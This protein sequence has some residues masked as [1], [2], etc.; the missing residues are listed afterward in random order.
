MMEVRIQGHAL[1]VC[2]CVHVVCS[3]CVPIWL[4]VRPLE[5]VSVHAPSSSRPPLCS[6]ACSSTA[7]QSSPLVHGAQQ[8]GHGLC[9]AT[10]GNCLTSLPSHLI[11]LLVHCTVD[12][13]CI[14]E[15]V[16]H[17][18]GAWDV[19]VALTMV[20]SIS[21]LGKLKLHSCFEVINF[22]HQ[23]QNEDT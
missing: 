3:Q 11:S 16:H 10:C 9:V 19:H 21:I 2:T 6:V 5:S 14:I 20:H 4:A 22:Y 18:A 12:A 17:H 1:P 7:A 8:N 23:L 15:Q 13:Y